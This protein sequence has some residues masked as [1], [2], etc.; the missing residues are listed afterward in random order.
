VVKSRKIRW[1]GFV[2]HTGLM[3]NAYRILVG[4]AERKR[5]RGGTSHKCEANI[6]MYLTEIMREYFGWIHLAQNVV[7]TVMKLQ[8]P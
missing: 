6:R 4:K 1:T 2:A 8:G 3:R 5:P 7:N